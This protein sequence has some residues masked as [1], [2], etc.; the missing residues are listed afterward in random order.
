MSVVM[1]C[2]QFR[3]AIGGAE[4]QAE[5]LSRTLAAK[6][7]TIA[8]LTP[9]LFAQSDEHEE[10]NGVSIRR[11]PLFDLSRSFPA[12]RGLGPLN[13]AALNLQTRRAAA[14]AIHSCDLVHA[15]GVCALTAFVLA[16][17]R[18]MGKP[19]LCK[20]ASSGAGFD[21]AKLA[22]IGVGGT[23][24]VAYLRKHVTAWT[25]TTEAV[26]TSLEEFGISKARIL[27]IPNGVA[28]RR[29]LPARRS[30]PP[31]RFLYVGRISR[32]C[33]RDFETLLGAFFRLA[34]EI[35]DVELALVGD[36]DLAQEISEKT[37]ASAFA[38][39]VHMPG[40]V[41]DPSSWFE[42]ADVFVLPSRREGMSNALIEAMASGLI[43]IANA[44]QAN[45]EVLDNGAAGHLAPV[46][47]MAGLLACMKLA[48]TDETRNAG[49]L[50]NASRRVKQQYEIGSVS[51]KYLDVYKRLL[52]SAIG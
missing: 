38:S 28:L 7:V 42:W 39:R 50:E 24:L 34:Q 40:F 1:F 36:G 15:H 25:A 8:I 16:A 21:L 5:I 2:S 27:R 20:A 10:A 29:G 43:C 47:D 11:F 32:A 19:F 23:W 41:D 31:R 4:R 48:V 35:S 9:K 17:S 44:I 46:E 12:I 14:H 51:L 33:G 30:G 37:K 26:A 18:R 13:L 22:A 49:L 3:P 45:R 52:N 6:G